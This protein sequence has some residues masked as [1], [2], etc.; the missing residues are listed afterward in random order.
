MVSVSPCARTSLSKSFTHPAIFRPI[1]GAP[2]LRRFSTHIYR[3]LGEDGHEYLGR[4]AESSDNFHALCHTSS[5]TALED[6]VALWNSSPNVPNSRSGEDVYGPLPREPVRVQRFFA[7]FLPAQILCV[8]LNYRAHAAETNKEPP[9]Q[10]VLA[11]FKPP[12]HT[13][14]GEGA[15]IRV[16]AIAK[17]EADFEAELGIVLG[18]DTRDVSEAD[19][20]EKILGFVCGNDVTARRWQGKKGGGQWTQSKSFDTF[21]PLGP[22]IRLWR[23]A[24]DTTF[25]PDNLA[26]R[27]H[28]NGTVMQDASTSDMI[29]SVR[30]IVSLLSRGMTLPR[31]TVIL[32]GTPA[33][34]GFARK[35]PVYLQHG[36]EIVVDIEGIGRLRNT[37]EDEPDQE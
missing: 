33:G 29:F 5:R 6:I 9:R 19:A 25:D 24:V 37:V 12:Q 15:V 11:A 10:P 14:I 21:C 16:P 8:G 20:H 36:D 28:L 26:I 30:S 31:G 23:P 22:N 17:N 18:Q 35:P 3:F 1:G 34:V 27:S 2:V 4:P 13:V 7:P 32:T